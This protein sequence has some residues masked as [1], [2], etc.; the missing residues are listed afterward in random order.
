LYA[1]LSNVGEVSF[2]SD[3]IY[4]DIG[5]ANYTKK[6]HIA[7]PA[8]RTDVSSANGKDDEMK[9]SDGSTS[10]HEYNQDAPAGM[11]KSLQDIRTGVDEKMEKSSLRLFRGSAAIR[12]GSGSSSDSE[13]D[14]HSNDGSEVVPYPEQG[15]GVTPL[16]RSANLE[17]HNIDASSDDDDENSDSSGDEESQSSALDEDRH[18][19][20]SDTDEGHHWK[21][22]IAEQAKLSFFERQSASL[23]LHELIYGSPSN[24]LV[25]NDGNAAADEVGD[26]ASLEDD[27]FFKPKQARMEAHTA[28][29]GR[30]NQ[31]KIST[32]LTED[33]SS[34]LVDRETSDNMN[35]SVF[36]W[37]E[38]GADSLI[39][40]IRDCFVTG[41]WGNGEELNDE[42]YG[43]FEDLET[44]EKF[45]ETRSDGIEVED[46]VTVDD[47]VG[48]TD[49]ERRVYHGKRKASKASERGKTATDEDEKKEG[50]ENEYIESAKRE[51]GPV[52][53]K[54]RRIR[55][56]GGEV[57]SATRGIPSRLI[58]PHRCRRCAGIV[59]VLVRPA[60]A[61]YPRW[62]DT[63]G[64]KHWSRTLPVE[65]AS[66]AQEDSE[67]QRSSC[68]LCGMAPLPECP[69][70][71][72]GRSERP[73]QIS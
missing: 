20:E 52:D 63:A 44:G 12:A 67:V 28:H 51:G 49:D 72:H 54:S 19:S 40:S 35:F 56:G 50:D 13:D 61:P 59:C 24:P 47:L 1:P 71:L 57:A 30:G 21:S 38:E 9:H 48:M 23:D 14:S 70:L 69:C 15:R 8:R 4:I 53:E 60:N 39:E 17:G 32:A 55:P 62:V 29:S 11:L 6:E 16:R 2:D 41:K 34:R 10:E 46:D 18:S 3:A 5:Q 26:E 58:L 42:E 45:G 68:L 43:E 66:V 65:E 37:M 27:E 25:T 33:D 36:Q 31:I 7:L 73:A 64:S 22:G